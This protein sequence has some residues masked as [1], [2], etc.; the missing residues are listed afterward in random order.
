VYKKVLACVDGSKPSIHALS[1]AVD[2]SMKYDSELTVLSVVEEMKFPFSAQFELWARESHE[3]LLRKVIESLN[4][5]ILDIKEKHPELRV[6]SRIIEGRPAEKIVEI[7][8]AEDFDIII[9][10]SRGYGMVESLVL[11]SISREVVNSSTKPV[12]VIK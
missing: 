3:E 4:T 6:E 9:L 8:E 2:L 7:A 10:G 1:Y 5:A 11:G 12:L